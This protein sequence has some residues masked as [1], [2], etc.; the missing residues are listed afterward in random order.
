MEEYATVFM[1][2]CKLETI[3]QVRCRF[4]GNE[5][6][7]IAVARGENGGQG[8]IQAW[9]FETRPYSHCCGTCAGKTKKPHSRGR[10]QT[11]PPLKQALNLPVPKGSC[12]SNE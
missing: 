3:S 2:C 11:C 9:G 7:P 12:L 1:K 6:E 8:R 4:H 5:V 10:F